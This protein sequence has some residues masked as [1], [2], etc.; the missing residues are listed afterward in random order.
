MNTEPVIQRSRRRHSKR[1]IATSIAALALLLLAYVYRRPI[2][3]TT[4]YCLGRSPACSWVDIKNALREGR[5][6][7]DFVKSCRLVRVD[8]EGYEL[9]TTPQG[10]WWVPR[11]CG[12]MLPGL[13]ATAEGHLY[14]SGPCQV[15]PGDVVLDCGA[16]LGVFT[17]EALRSGARRVVA[18][19]PAPENLECLRRNLRADIEAGRVIVYPKGLWDKDGSLT[20]RITPEFSAGDRIVPEGQENPE[21]QCVPVTTMD[22]LVAE[23]ALDQVDFIKI[24]VEGAEHQTIVGARETISRFRPK[25]AVSAHHRDD[26]PE[27]IPELVRAT[28]SGYQMRCTGCRLARRKLLVLPTVLLFFS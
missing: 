20:F 10:D 19:E 13:L 5:I 2:A 18:V 8:S 9:W 17:R 27:R 4:L 25:L 16:C 15:H 28:W 1:I 3:Y 24:H 11:D 14:Q 6:E 12:E 26:D 23:L 7:T 22:H 21:L